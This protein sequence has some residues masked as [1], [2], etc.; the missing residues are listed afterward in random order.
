M[1]Y[2]DWINN[3]IRVWGDGH[4]LA[5]ADFDCEG[6]LLNQPD[7]G[8]LS[9]AEIAEASAR[10]KTFAPAPVKDAYLRF[11]EL[12]QS[13]KSTNWATGESEGGVSCY[14]LAWD[15]V[16]AQYTLS[17]TGLLG[18]LISYTMQGVQPY[19]ITGEEVGKG[20]D[21]EP[22]LKNVKIVGSAVNTR[23]GWNI[24]EA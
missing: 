19:I 14:A 7:R 12:P 21:G 17:G 1:R 13:G 4:S 16:N 22:I 23:D 6:N 11:G 5:W 18:A 20:S 8:T 24:E 2:V 9:E 3:T 10:I 15:I